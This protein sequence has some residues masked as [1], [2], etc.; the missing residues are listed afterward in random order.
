ML[1]LPR[2]V[3]CFLLGVG[4]LWAAVARGSW[5]LGAGSALAFAA[6]G[7]IWWRARERARRRAAWAQRAPQRPDEKQ[8]YE[9]VWQHP[10]YRSSSPG[11][12]AVETFLRVAQPEA[13]AEV[14]D[15]GCGSGRGSMRLA[16]AGGLRVTMVDFARN[17]LNPSVQSALEAD[18]SP[19]RFVVA[20][21]TEALPV[22]AAYGFCCDVLEHIPPDKVDAVLENCLRAARRV[23]F[24][25]CTV[26][27]AFGKV[28]GFP[29]H[30]T[31]QPYEWWL[32]QFRERGCA[33]HWS[34][35]EGVNARFY[36]SAAH[37][38]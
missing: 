14:V 38:S 2:R 37:P 34:E 10:A 23:F 12:Q 22:S 17:C 33:I 30:L 31:V 26:E 3:A 21:L 7:W 32:T 27:D 24:Q 29:L 6:F 8:L 13:G 4:L 5:L 9:M 28:V 35:N 20:D 11:E 36:V 16:S 25:I 1:D 18:P 15:L 19:L